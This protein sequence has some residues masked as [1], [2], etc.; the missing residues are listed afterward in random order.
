ME[1]IILRMKELAPYLGL[2]PSTIY[3]WS[4]KGSDQYDDSFPVRIQL[5]GGSVG[6]LKAEIDDVVQQ[7][8]ICSQFW[9]NATGHNKKGT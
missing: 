2:S 5:G 3:N 7:K 1:S 6:W 9:R 8:T 4:D